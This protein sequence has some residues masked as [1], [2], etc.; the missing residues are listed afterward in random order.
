[1]F[2]KF[3]YYSRT[4]VNVIEQFLVSYVFSELDGVELFQFHF[5]VML[6]L[7][8]NLTWFLLFSFYTFLSFSIFIFYRSNPKIIN[9]KITYADL[10][11]T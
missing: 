5:A 2:I 8:L 10:S 1:M 11:D 4:V 7:Q 6:E 3:I 9:K